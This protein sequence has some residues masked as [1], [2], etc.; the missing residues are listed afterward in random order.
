MYFDIANQKNYISE[1]G[2][3][4]IIIAVN[5]GIKDFFNIEFINIKKNMELKKDLYR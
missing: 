1:C 5:K 2:N 4:Y 3:L